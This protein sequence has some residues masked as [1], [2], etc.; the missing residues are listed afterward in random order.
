MKETKGLKIVYL[1]PGGLFN[2]G[3]MERVTSIKVNY[4]VMHTN[5][6]ISI[7][8]TEQLNRPIFYPLSPRIQLYHLDIGIHE[9]FGKETYWQKCISRYKKIKE[10]KK[11]LIKLLY[12]IRPDITVST[13]GLDMEF[14][15]TLND[16]SLKIGELHFQGNF[17][18]LMADKLSEGIIAK[19]ISRVRTQKLYRESEKLSR[20]VVLTQEEKNFRKKKNNISVIPNPLPFFPEK[21]SSCANKKAIA[22]GRLVYEKGFDM[23]IKAWKAVAKKDPSWELHLY[24]NGNQKE[25][26]LQLIKEY[27]LEKQVWIHDAVDNIHQRYLESSL[28]IF[29][30]RYLEAF[31]MVIAEA[32]SC[33]IPVVAF[34]S[35]C[36]PKDLIT[37]G[38]D[39]F[40]LETGDIDG[41]SDRICTLITSPELRKKM[42][43][44]ARLT[45]GN[46]RKEIVMLQWINLFEKLSK[47]NDD[48]QNTTHP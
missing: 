40:L 3:G 29:P 44:A 10:Y 25:N 4:L 9:N 2:P 12:D 21:A 46:Y 27:N 37:D 35:P 17:R 6:Q 13:L 11:A 34:N 23:L 48:Y 18:E 1:L 26:L 33:G 39:G 41:L 14:L 8:T 20:L 38:I 32:M 24:G 31:G 28:L 47:T 7:V 43:E 15:H 5:Y 30:S 22:A 19:F 36:G 16:G 42:G 45:A